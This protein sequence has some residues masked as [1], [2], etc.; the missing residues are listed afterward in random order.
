MNNDS[1]NGSPGPG[2]SAGDGGSPGWGASAGDGGSSGWGACA[3]DGGSPAEI[4]VVGGGLAGLTAAILAARAGHTV[5]LHEGRRRLG[6][7]A[8]TDTRD[9]FRFNQGPHALYRGGPAEAVLAELGITPKGVTPPLAGAMADAGGRLE[10]LI[11][12][13]G[14]L[15]TSRLLGSGDK[16]AL[17]RVLT[18]LGRLDPAS[19][20]GLTVAQWLDG[21]TDREGTRR[22]LEA[23]V[24][25][26]SYTNAP[27]RLSAEV[28][29]T[30]LRA[31]LHHGVVYLDGGWGRLV[32]RLAEM[33]TA[34]G[35][36]MVRGD[37]LG[38]LPDA[39]AVIVAVG[40]PRAA[41]A[42]TGHPYPDGIAADVSVLDLGLAGR[43]S[44]DFV[45]GVDVPGVDTRDD[46]RPTYL[47]NHGVAGDMAPPG[48]TPVSVAR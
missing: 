2:A 1:V 34:V 9:G 35:V 12:G 29:V 13:P 22:V 23:L 5:T 37:R 19:V 40:S 24:R 30:Q 18:R 26:S 48:H 20:A 10:R 16:L 38:E 46:T 43:P 21:V 17:V 47:S 31:S 8:T 42:L 7:R 27:G 15:I 45:L 25:L 11:V 14:S 4:V 3:G 36:R 32:R 41:A 28:A 33:A 44:H 39:P 6:G